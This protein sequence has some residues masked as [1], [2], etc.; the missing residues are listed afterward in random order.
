MSTNDSPETTVIKGNVRL[1]KMLLVF[2]VGFLVAIVIFVSGSWERELGFVLLVFAVNFLYVAQNYR[3]Y[4]K[5]ENL[6]HDTFSDADNM[7]S[8]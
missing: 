1:G 4:R 3:D 5:L 8:K 6:I 7:V 2:Y